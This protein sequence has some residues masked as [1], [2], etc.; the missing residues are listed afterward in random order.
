MYYTLRE[1]DIASK[2][3]AAEYGL[4]HLPPSTHKILKEALYI[5]NGKEDR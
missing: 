1:N 2:D 5:R 3:K 4:A